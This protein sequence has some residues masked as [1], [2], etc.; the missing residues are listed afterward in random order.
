MC[1]KDVVPR[2]QLFDVTIKIKVGEVESYRIVSII[3]IAQS[4]SDYVLIHG[5][6]I[7]NNINIPERNKYSI[8]II[9]VEEKE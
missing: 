6:I 5:Y 8:V 1:L 2:E 3:K 9:T 4:T 7:M